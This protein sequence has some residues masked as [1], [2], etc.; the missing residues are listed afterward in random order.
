MPDWYHRMM[1]KPSYPIPRPLVG[2]D[3]TDINMDEIE[4]N[5]PILIPQTQERPP[6]PSTVGT[7]Q[8]TGRNGQ[9]RRD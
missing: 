7:D 2:K 6:G 9:S 5:N 1:S 4:R 3:L 8:P